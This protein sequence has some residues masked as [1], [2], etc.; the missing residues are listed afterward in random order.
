M[1]QRACGSTFL[2]R[3]F[4]SLFDSNTPQLQCWW[5]LT[6]VWHW[7]YLVRFYTPTAP[8]EGLNTSHN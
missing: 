6:V 1:A 4:F 8:Q 2:R 3:L 7:C 5:S